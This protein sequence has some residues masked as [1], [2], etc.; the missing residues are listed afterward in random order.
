VHETEKSSMS[1]HEI[2]INYK[3]RFN[4]KYVPTFVVNLNTNMPLKLDAPSMLQE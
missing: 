1:S 3:T 2:F 4:S